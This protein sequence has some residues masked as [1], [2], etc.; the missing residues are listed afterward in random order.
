MVHPPAARGVLRTTACSLAAAVA[1]L[2]A[3]TSATIAATAAITAA[4]AGPAAAQTVLGGTTTT[5]AAPITIPNPTPNP[6]SP[7]TTAAPATPTTAPP[8]P[9]TTTAPPKPGATGV[10]NVPVGG[11]P[12]TLPPPGTPPAPPAPQP[13]PAPI[14]T[15]VDSDLA[16]LTAIADYQPA[17]ALVAKAQGQVTEAS[18][19]LLS[20]RQGVTQAQAAESGAKQAKSTADGKLRQ[21]AVAAYI[22]V[23]FTS[24]GLNQPAQGNGD[25]GAGTV[26]TPDGLTGITAIDARE[27]LLIV[28]ERAHQM[29]E[30]A[31][32][33]V[34]QAHKSTRTANDAYHKAQATVAAAE[35]H[36]LAAQQT[37]K[38]IT[39]AA[40]T[41]GAAVATPLNALLD[42]A[43]NGTP[44]VTAPT[45]TS[46]TTTTVPAGAAVAA[47]DNNVPLPASPAILGPATLDAAH[48]TAWW[49]TLSRKPNITV[50]MDQLIA[51]YAKWGTKLGVAYDVAFAQS[52]VETGYFSFPSYG[53]LTDKD[54]NFAGIG[55]CDSCAHGWTFPDA[56][57]GALAQIEL[58]HEYATNS[59]LP[60]GVK[61]VIGTGIGGCCDTW[62]KLAGHWATST[63]YGISIMTVYH[64]ML[65]WLIPQQEQTVGLITPTSPAAKGPALAPLPGGKAAPTTVAPG[66]SA[67]SLKH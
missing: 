36:L 48:L 57:T 37:L 54:N 12:T 4:T 55:A 7:P 62:T 50:P 6:T 18:A 8:K 46:T 56:D 51:S 26:S 29:D 24:P 15:Q 41:P 1:L 32:Q 43:T 60:A 38:L 22:G 35:A 39:T 14:L 11:P 49:N 64:Q 44:P 31:A 34:S 52:I 66:V 17:Q 16:Q 65:A 9:T 47:A 25:Q 67:A 28:G 61:N 42:A 19:A 21:L 27:M 5:T 40:T 20:A 2:T 45:T 58:L 53:Q 63:V 59:P 13:D 33:V 30:D 10:P 3:G 23:G